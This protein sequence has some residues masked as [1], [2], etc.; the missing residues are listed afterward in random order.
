MRPMLRP[1]TDVSKLYYTHVACLLLRGR[2][3]WKYILRID[4]LLARNCER[5]L[6]CGITLAEMTLNSRTRAKTLRPKS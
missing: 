5:M 4:G 1:K 2:G 3:A 6:D